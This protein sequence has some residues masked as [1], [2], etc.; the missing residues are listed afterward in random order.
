MDDINN[1][2]LKREINTLD[3]ATN[4]INI[5]IASGIFLLPA[6]I[7]GVLGNSSFY[8][9][10]LCGFVLL[11]EAL[12]YAEMSSRFSN[13][14]GAYNYIEKAFGPF[15]GFL[16]NTIFWFGAGIFVSAAL[17]NG[18]AEMLSVSF[19]V[20]KNPVWR[21]L[22]FLILLIFSTYFNIRGV[23]SGMKIVR[24]FTYL[25]VLPL[26]V[27]IILGMFY[28]K[29]DNIHWGSFP[30]VGKLGEASLI[31]FFA[32]TGGECALNISGEIKNPNRS[33]PLGLIIG[34]MT[35]VIFYCLIQFIAQGVLG[36]D[37][38][39][40]KEAPL[41]A[42][43]EMMIGKTGASVLIVCAVL[44]IFSSFNSVI[45]VFPRVIFA[46]AN[47]GSLPTLFSKVHTKYATPYPAIIAFSIISFIISVSGGFKQLAVLATASML[48]MHLGV[49]LAT[50]KIRLK[51]DSDY[52]AK[53]KI[54]FGLTIP[55]LAAL[56]I[57][58]FL[59]QLKT[60]E[61]IGISIFI[62]LLSLV[63]LLNRFIKK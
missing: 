52:P 44:S 45:L 29:A 27:L 2:G 5:T 58:W 20:F 43:A 26:I 24:T 10:F 11:I 15:V 16:S 57:L 23:K 46:G 41:A 51:N 8:A 48:L 59:F 35:V 25:K 31:L 6:L 39:N 14:G 13:S 49:I 60:N 9:Y 33:A 18:L 1:E 47:Q 37:L 42:V 28:L 21:A 54:P 22:L 63:Y 61:I 55:V 40:H 3:V 38:I 34:V 32:F 4:V 50:I 62:G 12:C 30:S 36:P 7:V 17:L 19:P 53:F 56:T